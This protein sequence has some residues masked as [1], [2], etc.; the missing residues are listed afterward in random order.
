MRPNDNQSRGEQ[1]GCG[2]AVFC[3]YDGTF[4]VQDVGSTIARL[5]GGVTRPE[6]W[7]RYERGEIT[8]WEYNMEVLDGL[9]FSEDDLLAF[10]HTVDLDP[11][12]S[13]LVAWCHERGVPFRILSDGFDYNLDRLQKIHGVAFEYDANRLRY[14]GGAWSIAGGSPDASCGC[15]TGTCKRGR[16]QQFRDS[17]PDTAVVHIG[18]G[19]VSDLCGAIEA[20]VAFAKDSLADVLEAR[21]ITFERFETLCDV[22][23][24]LEALRDRSNAG[25]GETSG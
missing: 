9:R 5:H 15:G 17:H 8:A 18:N 21:G 16:I 20:D 13:D 23:P 12:A 7:A 1:N 3:D 19:R 14:E 10:L 6:V 22:I 25:V 2:L 24:R 4:S 11:G